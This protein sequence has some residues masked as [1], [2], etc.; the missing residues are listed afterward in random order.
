MECELY[1]S[2]RMELMD[3]I[4]HI[5]LQNDI[6]TPSRTT[7]LQSL[8]GGNPDHSKQVQGEILSAVGNYIFATRRSV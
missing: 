6:P 8:L 4:K 1:D 7:D 3:K 5:Y 2:E